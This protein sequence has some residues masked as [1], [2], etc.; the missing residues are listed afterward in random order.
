MLGGFEDVLGTGAFSSPSLLV[1]P[2][3]VLMIPALRSDSGES[4][5]RVERKF[6]L[7]CDE[8][9]TVLDILS[10]GETLV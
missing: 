3:V 10:R 4:G 2:M 8:Y 1:D 6:G 9:V 5:K 7:W